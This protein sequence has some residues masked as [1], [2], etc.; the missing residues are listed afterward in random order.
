MMKQVLNDFSNKSNF[1]TDFFEE[2]YSDILKMSFI[3]PC[4]V[5]INL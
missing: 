2:K 1:V 4:L 5:L 3:L